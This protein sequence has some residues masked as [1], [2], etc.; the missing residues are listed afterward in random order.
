MGSGCGADTKCTAMRESIRRTLSQCTLHS[1]EYSHE[2]PCTK[3]GDN[4]YHKILYTTKPTASSH[5]PC[6]A[7]PP[8]ISEYLVP[9]GQGFPSGVGH[10]D[11]PDRHYA[12]V[13]REPSS[14]L[15]SH[16]TQSDHSRRLSCHPRGV[17]IKE[18]TRK[19][20]GAP[21]N[22]R[23]RAPFPS[24]PFLPIVCLSSMLGHQLFNIIRT[25]LSH[26]IFP[27]KVNIPHV[28]QI[29]WRV[30]FNIS[31]KGSCPRALFITLVNGAAC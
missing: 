16:R 10:G 8:S 9:W 18:E 22:E 23:A 12:D 26:H 11:Q 3:G 15:H 1:A 6:L 5:S 27:Y 28:W 13:L 20:P 24:S 2:W 29:N 30:V 7:V 25:V 21:P 17:A 4:Y 31:T 19:T 14:L